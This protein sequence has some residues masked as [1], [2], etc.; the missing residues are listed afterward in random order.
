[1][2][3]LKFGG[4]SLS[5]GSSVKSSIEIIKKATKDDVAVIVSA[6]GDTTN[7]LEQLL[8]SAANGVPDGALSCRH[9]A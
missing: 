7:Q 1:M 3:V 6:R 5:N 2:K 8:I 9:D 4:K